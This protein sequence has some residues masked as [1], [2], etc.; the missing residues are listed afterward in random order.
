VRTLL[1]LFAF[2]FLASFVQA[3]DETYMA[4][5]KLACQQCQAKPVIQESKPS[6]PA[7][8]KWQCDDK[9]CRMVKVADCPCGQNCQCVNCQCNE[10]KAKSWVWWNNRWWE[11]NEYQA[12][13]QA[14]QRQVQQWSAGSYVASP[15]QS[16]GGFSG[17]AF[18]F[19]GGRMMSGGC[20]GG[21]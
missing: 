10:Q 7:G 4:K 6:A 14:Q 19:G 3:Q 13:A 16:F 18:G 11:Y 21:G 20:S 12:M 17:P 15:V 2:L 8:Y 9:G 1:A 5:A